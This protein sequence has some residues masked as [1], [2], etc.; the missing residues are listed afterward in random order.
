MALNFSTSQQLAQQ[1]GVKALVYSEAAR[2]KT[3]LIPTA[4]TPFILNADKGTLSIRQYSIPALVI[5]TLDDLR[6]AVRW[7]CSAHEARQFQT[8]CVDGVTTIAD[9]VLAD[10][11]AKARKDPR[12]AYGDMAEEV[13]LHM[14]ALR[15]LQGPNVY[16]TAEVE[17]R[18][19]GT[20]GPASPGQLVGRKLDYMFDEMF[21][22]DEYIDVQTNERT[23]F[24]RTRSNLQCIAKDRSGALAECEPADLSYIF[25]KIATS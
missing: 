7:V 8:F 13:L 25:N 12:L 17:Y 4:P 23:T 22:L 21:Y 14:R 1:A 19:D 6:D 10:M 2:G 20:K 9:A 3:R 5:S 15:D 18:K 16:M 11:K 24:L